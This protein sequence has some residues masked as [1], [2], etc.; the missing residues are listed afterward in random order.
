MKKLNWPFI[1]GMW[2][3]A[4]TVG[5]AVFKI[6]TMPDNLNEPYQWTLPLLVLMFTGFPFLCGYL[7]GKWTP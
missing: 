5:G 2:F 6:G 7:A 1:A 4:V 3:L